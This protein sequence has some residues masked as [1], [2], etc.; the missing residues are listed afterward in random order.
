M[1]GLTTP[2]VA[3]QG[4]WDELLI[5]AIPLA[6]YAAVRLWERVRGQAEDDV[7][8]TQDDADG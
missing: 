5:V 4:G 3:H 6:L 7:D 2:L 8:D 1:S